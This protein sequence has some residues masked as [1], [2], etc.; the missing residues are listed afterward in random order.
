MNRRL[1]IALALIASCIA[2]PSAHA[3]DTP[4]GTVTKYSWKSTIFPGTRSID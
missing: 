1:P 2:A 3:R 4:H